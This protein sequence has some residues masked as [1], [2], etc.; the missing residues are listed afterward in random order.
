MKILIACEE[1]QRVC[2][3][4]RKLGHEA[5]SCD[6]KFPSGGNFD[7]HIR[8]DALQYINGDCEFVTMDGKAHKIIGEWDLLIAHPPCTYLSRAATSAMFK[9]GEVNQ[10]R[11]EI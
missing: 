4:M 10:E 3:N 1:S 9:N 6:L 7:W 8:G 5:Y 11:Y 2:N